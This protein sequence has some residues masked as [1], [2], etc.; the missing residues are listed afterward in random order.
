M[1]RLLIGNF[2]FE[3]TLTHGGQQS[4]AALRRIVAQLACTWGVAAEDGDVLWTPQP[5]D[6]SFLDRLADAGLPRLRVASQTNN[7]PDGL[8]LTPWGWTQDVINVGQK[9]HAVVDAPPQPVVRMLNSRSFSF[10][11][12]QQCGLGLT[13]SARVDSLSELMT[14]IEPLATGIA[15]WVVKA[16]FSNS[17]RERFVHRSNSPVDVEAL[18]IWAKR[19]LMPGQALFIE[20]WVQRLDEVGVQMTIPRDGQPNIDGVTRLLVDDAGHFQGCEFTASLDHDPLWTEARISALEVASVAQRMGYFGPLGIDAMRY[21]T[22]GGEER[23]R[24]LQ[25]INARWTM[26]RLSLGLRRLLGERGTS[27]PR[28]EAGVFHVKHSHAIEL[29]NNEFTHRI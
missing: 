19:R 16:E 25:D 7:I 10:E 21:R 1:P 18:K 24:P 28:W 26:G 2:D 15:G 12:E 8:T 6:E 13:R 5:I 23:L 29:R 14:A 9:L 27:V 11:Q 22:S 17:S 20:P 3:H 4:S